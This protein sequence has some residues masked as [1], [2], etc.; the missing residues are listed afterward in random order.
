MQQKH[1]SIPLHRVALYLI[2]FQ[3]G[4]ALFLRAIPSARPRIHAFPK[5]A[6]LQHIAFQRI[7]AFYAHPVPVLHQYLLHPL[8]KLGNKILKH[9]CFLLR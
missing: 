3:L 6:A 5:R 4:Q 1:F 8:L 9:L 7:G 2:A